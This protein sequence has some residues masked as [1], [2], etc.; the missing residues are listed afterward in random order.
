MEITQN[1]SQG[2]RVYDPMGIATTVASGAGGLG[3]KTG[4]YALEVA[5]AVTSSAYLQR[6]EQ[7]RIDGKPSKEP[8]PEW[9]RR[10]RRLTPVECERL[11]GFPDGWTE[12]GIDEDGREIKISDTQRYRSLGNAVSTNVIKVIFERWQ[13]AGT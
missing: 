4:L 11:Q 9:K 10:I 2:F 1:Q 12:Y 13:I 7:E 6:G 5:N 8:T 3:A